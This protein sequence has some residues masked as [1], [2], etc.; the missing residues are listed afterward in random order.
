[1][2]PQPYTGQLAAKDRLTPGD[3]ASF[4]SGCSTVLL[5]PNFVLW[6]FV[7]QLK[8]NKFGAYWM[9]PA[10]MRALMDSIQSTH[11]YTDAGKKEIVRNDLAVL[12]SWRNPKDP[13]WRPHISWRL[14]I[15]LKKEVIAHLGQIGP[16]KQFE[17]EAIKQPVPVDKAME[18]RVGG[19]TQYVIPGFR[20]LPD[21]NEWA[22]IEHFAHI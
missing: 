17:S 21:D 14:K 13:E 8:D 4:L 7:S 6:R 9:D 19:Y 22:R 1:M 18:H 10:T 5:P 12:E 2:G 16:Q 3:L 15:S 11:T 20:G